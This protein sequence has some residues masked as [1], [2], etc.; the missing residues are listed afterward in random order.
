MWK[1]KCQY[2]GTEYNDFYSSSAW[3]WASGETA[4]DSH[5]KECDK[6]SNSPQNI[7]KRDI[8]RC[9]NEAAIFNCLQCQHY[10]KKCSWTKK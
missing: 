1:A 7:L 10:Q 9:Q 5:E 4:R 3:W 6:N 8:V 2:C